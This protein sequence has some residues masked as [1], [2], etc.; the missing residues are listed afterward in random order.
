M[1]GYYMYRVS[2]RVYCRG[3]CPTDLKNKGLSGKISFCDFSISLFFK[4]PIL[5]KGLVSLV[6]Y[7]YR[8]P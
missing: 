7:L 4:K 5:K 3:I 2:I 6:E 8:G 1:V